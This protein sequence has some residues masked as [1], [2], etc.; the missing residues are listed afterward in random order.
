ML[1]DIPESNLIFVRR[2]TNKAADCLARP[3]SL[4]IDLGDSACNPPA[5]FLL[6]LDS[7]E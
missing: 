2:S 7:I 3:A 1:K 6:R 4:E 5:L